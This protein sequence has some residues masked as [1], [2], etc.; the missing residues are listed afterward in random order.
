MQADR[1]PTTYTCQKK[2]NNHLQ[3]VEAVRQLLVAHGQDAGGHIGVAANELGG[4]GRHKGE[5]GLGLM[6]EELKIDPTAALDSP[7]AP[8]A[9]R[10][11]QGTAFCS[12]R[13]SWQC[14]PPGPA[15][16]GRCR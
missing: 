3:E 14:L 13:R 7:A 2:Q 9:H 10:D 5:W 12:H 1:P 16:A 6:K 4:C 15:A 11:S 8:V